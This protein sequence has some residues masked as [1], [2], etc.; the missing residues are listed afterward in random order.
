MRDA[1]C[2]TPPGTVRGDLG[3]ETAAA[4]EAIVH[5]TFHFT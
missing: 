1:A 5:G 3:A 2:Q 4:H